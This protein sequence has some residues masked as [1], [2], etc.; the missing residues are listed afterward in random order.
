MFQHDGRS[1]VILCLATVRTSSGWR[2]RLLVVFYMSKY[3]N[4]NQEY[5][6]QNAFGDTM[7]EIFEH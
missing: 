6:L 2:A 3:Y 4:E 7:L 1:F 5:S